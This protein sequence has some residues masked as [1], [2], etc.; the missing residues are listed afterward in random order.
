MQAGARGCKQARE[1]ASERVGAARQI[2]MQSAGHGQAHHLVR[3]MAEAVRTRNDQ[4][5]LDAAI[6]RER[7]IATCSSAAAEG[8]PAQWNRFVAWIRGSG[9][10]YRRTCERALKMERMSALQR[11]EVEMSL[12]L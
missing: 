4:G 5:A 2:G 7:T 6:G 1:D 10:P 3:L 12:R 11:L 9:A 8:A